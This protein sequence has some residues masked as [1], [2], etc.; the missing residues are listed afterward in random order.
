MTVYTQN[1]SF[2]Q[3]EEHVKNVLRDATGAQDAE[4]RLSA[5]FSPQPKVQVEERSEHFAVMMQPF[6]GAGHVE[7]IC[8]K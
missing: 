3:L 8:P 2:V 6:P 4:L 5:Y 1:L 7:I